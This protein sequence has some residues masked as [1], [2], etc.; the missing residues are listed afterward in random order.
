MNTMDMLVITE[1]QDASKSIKKTSFPVWI[2]A[3][4]GTV[5]TV[6]A[7]SIDALSFTAELCVLFEN[8]K[9]EFSVEL[10]EQLTIGDL[11]EFSLSSKLISRVSLEEALRS[12]VSQ[13]IGKLGNLDIELS[14]YMDE[15]VVTLS[16]QGYDGSGR[17]KPEELTEFLEIVDIF[18]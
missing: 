4:P 14:D 7:T 1:D 10:L 3:K 15:L 9:K 2:K 13:V 18:E 16:V 17:V 12:S 6:Q 5:I 8:G 11:P